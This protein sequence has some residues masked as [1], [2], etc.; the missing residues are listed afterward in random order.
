MPSE[1]FGW[2]VFDPAGMVIER[3]IVDK[4]GIVSHITKIQRD[5][6][7][8]EIGRIINAN[9][10]T[11]EVRRTEMVPTGNPQ[12]VSANDYANEKLVSHTETVGDDRSRQT[13][14]FDNAEQQPSREYRTDADDKTLTRLIRGP[15]GRVVRKI[16]QRRDDKGVMTEYSEYD[17]SDKLLSTMHFADGKLTYGF[18]DA[19]ERRPTSMG[20]K[21]LGKGKSYMWVLFP[22][23]GWETLV[24]NHPNSLYAEPDNVERVDQNG[25]VQERLSFEYEH[26]AHGNWTSMKATDWRRDTD[27]TV[28]VQ[29]S[30]RKIEYFQ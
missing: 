11:P 10:N 9:S 7:E 3:G 2:M 14:V 8:R 4:Q 16:V 20:V 29:T 6:E 19:S 5:A 12:M 21:T 24:T 15:D 1:G 27:R 13:R 26:D 30:T 18:Q 28:L 23:G 22:G 17:G 25:V